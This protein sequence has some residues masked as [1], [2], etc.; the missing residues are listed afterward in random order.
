MSNPISNIEIIEDPKY[1]VILNCRDL[2]LADRFED[3]LTEKC[4]ALFQIKFE[5]NEVSFFFSQASS[6]SKVKE[7]F[8]R[9][10]LSS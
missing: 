3:F 9:F 6:I 8:D 1:G 2:E 7:L 5:S 4:F 10:M